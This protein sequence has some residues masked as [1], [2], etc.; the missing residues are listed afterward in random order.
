[1]EAQ[2]REKRKVAA[3]KPILMEK[4]IMQIQNLWNRI[5]VSILHIHLSTETVFQSV[6]SEPELEYQYCPD[7]QSETAPDQSESFCIFTGS[8][9]S[10][11]K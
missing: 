10:K 2:L 6:G 4:P 1:M 3:A 9:H 11:C 5:C 7:S 8:D